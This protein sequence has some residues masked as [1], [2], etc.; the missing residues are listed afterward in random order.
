MLERRGTDAP[1]VIEERIAKA[2]RELTYA[3]RFDTILINDVLESACE[4]AVRRVRDFVAKQP[5]A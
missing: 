4:E 1:E 2:A 3:G 5:V